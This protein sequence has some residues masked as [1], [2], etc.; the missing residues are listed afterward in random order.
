MSAFQPELDYDIDLDIASHDERRH[1]C[2]RREV[3]ESSVEGLDQHAESLD[4]WARIK[5]YFRPMG[6]KAYYSAVFHLLVLNFPFALLAWV[7]LF[8]FTLVGQVSPR[9]CLY[10]VLSFLIDWDNVA[11]GVAV[12]CIVVFP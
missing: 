9:P 12:R 1:L 5:R 11:R 8:V 2:R 3:S 6:R 7:Y 10:N 4:L